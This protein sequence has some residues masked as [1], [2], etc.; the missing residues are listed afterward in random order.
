MEYCRHKTKIQSNQQTQLVENL[1]K[2]ILNQHWILTDECMLPCQSNAI[3]YVDL[4]SVSRKLPF[5]NKSNV[6]SEFWFQSKPCLCLQS[7]V[8]TLPSLTISCGV[9]HKQIVCVCQW[10]YR[11]TYILMKDKGLRMPCLPKSLC[12]LNISHLYREH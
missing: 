11:K 7:A 5:F 4:F 9:F 8:W 10:K 6:I 1:L 3:L 12:L 2:Y